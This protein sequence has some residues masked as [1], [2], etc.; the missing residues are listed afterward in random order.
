[1]VNT[2]GSKEQSFNKRGTAFFGVQAV[3]LDELADVSPAGLS[4]V[5]GVI[6]FFQFF[7]EQFG[8][9]SFST[10]IQALNAD[11]DSF[12]HRTFSPSSSEL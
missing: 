12:V 10:T 11:E 7:H 9:R 4:R 2:V 1:M 5:H 3:F 6:V 8:L